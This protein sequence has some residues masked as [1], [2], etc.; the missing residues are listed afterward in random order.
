MKSRS[1]LHIWYIWLVYILT[2]SHL[3]SLWTGLY[4]AALHPHI[5]RFICPCL[6]PCIII[7]SNSCV[8]ACNLV[9]SHLLILRLMH[10]V[11]LLLSSSP[12]ILISLC[13]CMPACILHPYILIS[14]GSYICPCL[15]PCILITSG[16]CVLACTLASSHPHILRFI[17]ACWYPRIFTFLYPQVYVCLLVCPYP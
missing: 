10:S 3:T 7:S 4:L 1:N 12:H 5:F 16:S 8:L 15:H 2:S 9:S 11:C 14:S 17:C 13:S 6:H